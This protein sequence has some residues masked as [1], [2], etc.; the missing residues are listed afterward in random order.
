MLVSTLPSAERMVT[1]VHHHHCSHSLTSRRLPKWMIVHHLGVPLA[2]LVAT[3]DTHVLTVVTVRHPP[4]GELTVVETV[5]S[6]PTLQVINPDLPCPLT[7]LSS[8]EQCGGMPTNT[9]QSSVVACLQTQGNPVWWHAYKHRAIQCGGMPTNTGQSSVVACLQT[10]GNPVWWHAYKHRAIQC[11]GMP[12]NTGQSSAVACLQTQGN[13]VRWHAYR[14]RAI[15][16][17]HHEILH[18]AI[19]RMEVG[20]PTRV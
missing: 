2:N 4:A 12:T 14:H 5:L 9:G 11:G 19:M 10:Q 7:L 3:S 15:Q 20:Y 16:T 1:A 13:P 8:R 18:T 17:Y 6:V